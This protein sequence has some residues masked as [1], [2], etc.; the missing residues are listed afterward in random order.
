MYKVT[1]DDLRKFEAKLFHDGL[2]GGGSVVP[3]QLENGVNV[4]KDF[5]TLYNHRDITVRFYYKRNEHGVWC[6]LIRVQFE[7]YTTGAVI[8][9]YYE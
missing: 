1:K 2:C 4:K 8:T 3:V 6:D 5:H 7:N 9:F